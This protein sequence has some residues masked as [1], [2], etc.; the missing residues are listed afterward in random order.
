MTRQHD[1]GIAEA[2][3]VWSLSNAAGAHRLLGMILRYAGR[4]E[5]AIPVLEKAIRLN[6]FPP[7]IYY[8]NLGRHIS[9]PDSVTKRSQHV[10]KGFYGQAAICPRT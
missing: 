5:E 7:G 3:R 6:P 8:S 1:K 4:P 9:I 10:K 2:K